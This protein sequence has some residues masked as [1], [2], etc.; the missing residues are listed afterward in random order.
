M[1]REQ[2]DIEVGPTDR[3]LE[4]SELQVADGTQHEVEGE[5]IL[6]RQLAALE[7]QRAE[8]AAELAREREARQKAEQLL[9]TELDRRQVAEH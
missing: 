7:R 3:S 6:R 4:V 2:Q 1:E 5:A 8:D 9:A